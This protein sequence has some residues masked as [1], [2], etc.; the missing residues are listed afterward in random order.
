[1]THPECFHTALQVVITCLPSSQEILDVEKTNGAGTEIEEGK[2]CYCHYTIF[3]IMQIAGMGPSVG[4]D[5][6]VIII[7]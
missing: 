1:M 6:F 4:P 2:S 7:N 5:V 3:G